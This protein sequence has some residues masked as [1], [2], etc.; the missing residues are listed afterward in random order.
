M[1]EESASY[2]EKYFVLGRSR[3]HFAFKQVNDPVYLF[4]CK[5]CKKALSIRLKKVEPG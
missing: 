1:G 4:R 5:H 3:Y 2:A